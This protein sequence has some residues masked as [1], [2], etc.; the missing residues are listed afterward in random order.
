VLGA[1]YQAGLTIGFWSSLEE[2]ASLWKLGKRFEPK[3]SAQERERLNLGRLN[4]LDGYMPESDRSK[5]A[6][7]IGLRMAEGIKLANIGF[8]SYTFDGTILAMDH[9][10]FDFFELEGRYKNP[11]SL[12]GKKIESLFVYTGPKGRLRHELRARGKVSNLEYGIRTLKNTEKWGVHNS[13]ICI[14][15]KTGEEIIQVCFYDISD[16]KLHEKE[17]IEQS[18]QRYKTLFEHSPDSIIILNLEYRIIECNKATID[19][20]NLKYENIIGQRIEE[21]GI[22]DRTQ[23]VRYVNM[24]Q[25][26]AKGE[27]L[28][29]IEVELI[30]NHGRSKWIESFPSLIIQSGKPDGIQII[31][32]D[33]TDRKLVE[34]AMRKKIMKYQLENGII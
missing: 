34:I 17:R 8:Y 24:L 33:I 1:I 20:L 6:D 18:E 30:M 5:M 21:L 14:N 31:S 32:R 15:Q 19:I 7:D 26:M 13:Y 3:I 11:Q 25:S 10:S 16:R 29:T 27:K 23:A 22:L 28:E 9:V 2:T 4:V 12:I